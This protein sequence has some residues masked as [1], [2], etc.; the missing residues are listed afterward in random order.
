MI[1]VLLSPLRLVILLNLTQCPRIVPEMQLISSNMCFAKVIAAMWRG[2]AMQIVRPYFFLGNCDKVV[3]TTFTDFSVIHF[4]GCKQVTA[5]I[6]HCPNLFCN[7]DENKKELNNQ[8]LQT[9]PED[10]DKLLIGASKDI[11]LLALSATTKTTSLLDIRSTI[12]ALC[13][14][15][16]NFFL[17]LMKRWQMQRF[18]YFLSSP[19]VNVVCMCITSCRR[20]VRN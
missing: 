2:C 5:L 9:V 14:Y 12:S 13:W 10:K 19:S 11:V 16:G 8:R 7:Y 3:T 15:T 1:F 18:F 4:C 17:S 6:F 20:E